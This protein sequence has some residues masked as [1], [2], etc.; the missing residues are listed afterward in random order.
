MVLAQPSPHGA[1]VRRFLP[2]FLIF[3]CCMQP[4]LDALSYWQ[5]ALSLSGSLSL[6]PRMILL[7]SMVLLAFSLSKRKWLYFCTAGVLVLFWVCHVL[8]CLQNGYAEWSEDLSNYIRVLQLPLTAL[9]M[10]TFLKYEESSFSA[11]FRGFFYTFGVIVLLQII[12]LI[13][14]T[15]PYTYPDKQI[16]LRGWCFWPNAQ[17]AILSLLAPICIVYSLQRWR[18]KPLVCALVIL[19]CL[20]SLFLH[21][22]R[23]AYLCLFIV[24]IGLAVSLLLLR[25][26]KKY[27]VMLLVLCILS[28][29]LFSV[30]PMQRNQ[31]LVA[32]NAV[33][34]TQI[35]EDLVSIGTSEAETQNL[36]GN[37][38]RAERLRLG[39]TYFCDAMVDRFGLEKVLDAYNYTE[40][41]SIIANE[42]VWKL[43]YCQ[44]LMADSTSLSKVFGLSVGR[45]IH[46]GV[47]HD[48][49]NDFHGIYYLY[50]FAGLALLFVFLGYFLWLI[51]KA[52]LKAPKRFF[53]PEA[54]AYGIAF[55]T[56]LIH[57]YFTCGVLRRAN[58]LFYFGVILAVIYYL[59]KLRQY[60]DAK[61]S[62]EKGS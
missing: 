19:L 47:S 52:M 7:V 26:P 32:E 17:S 8:V 28:G 10:I 61:L 25:Q 53:T 9:C 12:A 13:T 11:L 1:R 39:Y 42:R 2:Y 22:T 4:V 20:G 30:S 45:M 31:K 15:E 54:A 62:S 3:L 16:G 14:G 33:R 60:P 37:A 57:S 43:K 34:K 49:E 27:V 35:F 6:A 21:G 36:T 24:G 40:D 59:V 5:D 50:G 44:L 48:V 18:G 41:V 58:T 38:F 29:A 56:L 46:N 55:I 51:L 23:L